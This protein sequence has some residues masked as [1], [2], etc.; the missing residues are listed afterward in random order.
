M[1]DHGKLQLLRKTKLSLKNLVLQ[2]F[3]FQVIV[4]IQPDLSD[5]DYLRVLRPAP[6]QI[7][8]FVIPRFCVMGMPADSGIKEIIFLRKADRRLA[9]FLIAADVYHQLD[10]GRTQRTDQ[11]FSVG[12]EPFVVIMRV[13]IK[14]HK[15]T[16]FCTE[17][18]STIPGVQQ[19]SVSPADGE[20]AILLLNRKKTLLFRK[21]WIILKNQKILW[22]KEESP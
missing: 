4:I 3:P 12:I 19:D 7:G 5:G 16:S 18:C 13:G 14:I 21:D 1:D 20:D 10:A 6:D 8:A 15:R 22:M 2:G 17:H 11:R 9:G